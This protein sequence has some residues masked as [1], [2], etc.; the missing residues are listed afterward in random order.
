M[1]L[2]SVCQRSCSLLAGKYCSRSKKI[3]EVIVMKKFLGLLVMLMMIASNCLAMTF[4]QPVEIGSIFVTPSSGIVIRGSSYNSGAKWKVFQGETTYREG[5]AR[6]G[7]EQTGIY[8]YYGKYP[9]NFG[10]KSKNFP[11]MI[12]VE[13]SISKIINDENI[14]MYLLRNDGSDVRLN[15]YFL[16]GRRQ[17][18]EWIK[19]FDASEFLKKYFGEDRFVSLTKAYCKTN[20]ITID[21]EKFHINDRRKVGALRFKWDNVAQW[22]SVEKIVY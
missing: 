6:W 15:N 13:V 18:G 8:F 3:R 16:L 20:S 9:F 10:G 11:L 14:T 21:V 1:L 12:N 22:F 4:S 19:Y 17:D 5:V 2:S 7:D